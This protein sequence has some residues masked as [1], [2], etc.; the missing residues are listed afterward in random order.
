MS[1]NVFGTTE[2]GIN[3]SYRNRQC[4]MVL[5]SG[6]LWAFERNVLKSREIY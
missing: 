2:V 1:I 5:E 3:I 6:M 4:N